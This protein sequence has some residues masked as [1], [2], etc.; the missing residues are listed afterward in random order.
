MLQAAPELTTKQLRE[1]LPDHTDL[2]MSYDTVPEY[3]RKRRRQNEPGQ[4]G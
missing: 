4:T 2:T 3:Q 1:Q